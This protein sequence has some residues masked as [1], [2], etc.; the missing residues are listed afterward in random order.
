[1]LR[2]LTQSLFLVVLILA[3][4]AGLYVYYVHNSEAQKLAEVQQQKKELEQ[5]IQR[6]ETDRRVARI[7]VSSQQ[8]DDSSQVL[9]TTL[10]FVEYRRDGSA[11]P[12]KQF[13]ITGD[14]AHFDAE[15]IKF[16]DEYVKAGDPLRGQS[17]ILFTRVYGANQAPADGF[18]ID[19][20]GSIPQI[21]RGIDPTISS[22]EQDLWKNFWILYND[23]NARDAQGIRGLH[24]EGLW[25]H[26]AMNHIYTITLRPD[27]GTI[28]EEP[29]EPIYQSALSK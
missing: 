25:G 23:K 18:P 20:P 17:I 2:A 15:I 12:A 7:L 6:L 16:K 1:M 27:G 19:E 21:Y 14:E 5:V 26:F 22:F 24:G 28:S 3:G 4:S 11:L 13:T 10:L 9:K 29:V 8:T